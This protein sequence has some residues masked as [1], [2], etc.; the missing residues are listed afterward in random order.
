M[1]NRENKWKKWAIKLM[2]AL[3]QSHTQNK[4][5]MDELRDTNKFLHKPETE[6]TDE[7]LDKR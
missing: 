4:I 2:V 6:F 7:P 3:E 5:L 1:I